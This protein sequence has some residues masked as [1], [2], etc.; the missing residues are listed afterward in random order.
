MASTSPSMARRSRESATPCAGGG[1]LNVPSP[2]SGFAPR[3]P[4]STSPAR[5]GKV[6]PGCARPVSPPY[7]AAHV[8]LALKP[9]S[10]LSRTG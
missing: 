9:L 3:G 1:G 6:S 2:G 10:P 8:A 4:L 5:L 7:A